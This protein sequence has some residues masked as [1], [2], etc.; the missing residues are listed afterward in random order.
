[1]RCNRVLSK[2][3]LATISV[4]SDLSFILALDTDTEYS[5][6]SANLSKT[7]TDDR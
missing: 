2:Y 4:I 1:M 6:F 5:F 3:F 7:M